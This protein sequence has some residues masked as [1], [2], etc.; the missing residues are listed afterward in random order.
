MVVSLSIPLR[1]E[2]PL[3]PLAI[4]VVADDLIVEV[5]GPVDLHRA[6]DVAG[7]VEQEVFVRFHQPDL[8][9]VRC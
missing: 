8:G 2:Q 9:V 4:D 5:V 6:R 1:S 7:I 3:Q